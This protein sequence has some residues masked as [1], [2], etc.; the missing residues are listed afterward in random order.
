MQTPIKRTSINK[1]LFIMIGI[2]TV[3]IFA[4][5]CYY[6]LRAERDITTLPITIGTDALVFID[7]GWF[8]TNEYRIAFYFGRWSYQTP[9]GQWHK[10][11]TP[12]IAPWNDYNHLLLERSGEILI[13][14]NDN[15][16]H[17]EVKLIDGEWY[18]DVDGTWVTLI[19]YRDP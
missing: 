13:S 16:D 5:C 11:L 7:R 15:T 2:L 1:R 14:S 17:F 18:T 12:F 4:T 3:M 8:Q 19:D 9:D 10:M 6:I